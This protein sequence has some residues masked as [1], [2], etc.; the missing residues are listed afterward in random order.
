MAIA[1]PRQPVYYY[2]CSAGRFRLVYFIPGGELQRLQDGG[3]IAGRALADFPDGIDLDCTRPDF[4]ELERIYGY[5]PAHDPDALRRAFFALFSSTHDWERFRGSG[6]VPAIDLESRIEAV[7]E[8]LL[9]HDVA[10]AELEPLPPPTT[11]PE[12]AERRTQTIRKAALQTRMRQ[13]LAQ[14]PVRGIDPDRNLKQQSFSKIEWDEGP[15][16]EEAFT[17]L[18]RKQES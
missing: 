7:D 15:P 17:R 1:S 4:D 6:F 8:T 10:P 12:L 3:L 2:E 14:M 13:V 18:H 5:R 11:T 9:D 16:A